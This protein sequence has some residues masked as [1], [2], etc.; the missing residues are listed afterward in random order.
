LYSDPVST[1]LNDSTVVWTTPFYDIAN[2]TILQQDFGTSAA[3]EAFCGAMSFNPAS[4]L[5]DHTPVGNLQAIRSRVYT[6]MATL[7]R[8]LSGQSTADATYEDWL[9]YPDM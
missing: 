2:I 8:Q 9:N 5:A 6:D 4:S 1:P 3:Q 7:R